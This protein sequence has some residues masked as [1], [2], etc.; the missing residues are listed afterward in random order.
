[1]ALAQDAIGALITLLKA[2][3]TIS[4]LLGTRV[5]G[6]E[7]PRADADSMPRKAIVINSAGGIGESSYRDVFKYRLDFVC[8]GET[9]FEAYEVFRTV[10]AVLREIERG[11]TSSTFIYSADHSAGPFSFRDSDT[12]WPHTIDT[13]LIKVQDTIVS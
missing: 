7:L 3:A 6:L 11:V 9:P 12:K 10:R 1:M 5:Y 2:D 13:W 4:A 8:Y